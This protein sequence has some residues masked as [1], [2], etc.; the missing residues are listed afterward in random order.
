MEIWRVLIVASYVQ[1][2][3]S[4]YVLKIKK[5]TAKEAEALQ[6]YW[7]SLTNDAVCRINH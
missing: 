7:A 1:Q 6:K 3:T 2:R 5:E 4:H